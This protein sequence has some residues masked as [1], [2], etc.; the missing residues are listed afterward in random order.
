ME[1]GNSIQLYIGLMERIKNEVGEISGVSGSRQGQV[2]N[3]QAVGN[4][5]TEMIQS[6]HVTEYWFLQ[7]EETQLRVMKTLL[8]VAKYAWIDL[9]SKKVQHV[10]DNG[11]T[12]IY[13]IDVERFVEAD[14]DLA[15]V[16]G[17]D[18]NMLDTVKQLAHAGLQNKMLKFSELIDILT[19]DS[20]ASVKRKLQNKEQEQEEREIK[21]QEADREVK[22]QQ[23]QMLKDTEELKM[24]NELEKEIIKV[25]GRLA[26]KEME[27][28]SVP[29]NKLDAAKFELEVQKIKTALSIA[30]EKLEEDKRKNKVKEELEREK[31]KVSRTS[32]KNN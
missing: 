22:L 4:T 6:N 19:T 1:M 21:N 18:D 9:K 23:S 5:K 17:F 8:E 10:L 12:E 15:I 30:K 29:E 20:I 14:Y 31:I 11:T 32:R 7:H 16:N 28:A 13:N 24:Q 3:R 27:I 26:E 25:E 2:Y